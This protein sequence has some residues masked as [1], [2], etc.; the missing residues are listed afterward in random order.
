M[1]D[2]EFEYTWHLKLEISVLPA[3][4]MPNYSNFKMKYMLILSIIIKYLKLEINN[5]TTVN[6]KLL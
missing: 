6:A 2:T 3:Q 4:W 5:L 1:N